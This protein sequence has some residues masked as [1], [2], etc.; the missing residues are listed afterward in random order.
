MDEPSIKRGALAVLAGSAAGIIRWL[1]LFVLIS[2]LLVAGIV[3]A[4]A[5]RKERALPLKP[6]LRLVPGISR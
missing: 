5:M 4:V 1:V 3:V 6:K 2:L